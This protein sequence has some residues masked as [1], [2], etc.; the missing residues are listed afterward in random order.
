M[1]FKIFFAD[2]SKGYALSVNDDGAGKMIRSTDGG[3]TWTDETTPKQDLRG[4]FFLNTNLGFAVGD[5]GVILK[6]AFPASVTDPETE[7]A[8][9]LFYPNPFSTS[10]TIRIPSGMNTDNVTLNIYNASGNKTDFKVTTNKSDIII[11]R[12][13]LPA[14]TYYYEIISGTTTVGKGTFMVR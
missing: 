4:L 11:H 9:P 2:N 7:S 6:Y 10:A 1:I 5:N 12:G 13:T 14:G 3:V 8:S